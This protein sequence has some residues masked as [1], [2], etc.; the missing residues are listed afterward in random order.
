M[1][2]YVI[3]KKEPKPHKTYQQQ[4]DILVSRGMFIKDIK[5]A[6]RKLSHIGYYRLSGYWYIARKEAA[7]SNPNKLNKRLDNFQEGTIFEDFYNLYLFDKD[8]RLHLFCGIERIENYLKAI[9]AYELGKS[10]PCAHLNKNFFKVDKPKY[11]HKFAEYRKKLESKIVN[12]KDDF[13]KW[14]YENYKNIPIWVATEIW[15]FGMLSNFYQILKHNYQQSIC[16]RLGITDSTKH[17]ENCLHTLNIIRN[18]CA[19]NSRL[20]NYSVK[21]PISPRLLNNLEIDSLQDYS[22]TRLKAVIL[23]IWSLTTRFSKNSDWLIKMVKLLEQKPNIPNVNYYNMGFFNNDL[24]VLYQLLD[25]YDCTQT[26]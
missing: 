12:S 19:H 21:P 8:I 5:R 25:K 4:I 15:D 1:S 11:N 6:K 14:N 2:Y 22:L 13:I 24:K 20:W 3:P 18:K 7:N 17:L 10:N 16:T 9:I 23:A 26:N